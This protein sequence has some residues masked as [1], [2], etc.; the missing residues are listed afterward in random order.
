MILLAGRPD[1][2]KSS[3]FSLTSITTAIT[4]KSK[5][6]NTKVK[7]KFFSM[8]QSSFFM[9]CPKI[10]AGSRLAAKKLLSST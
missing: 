10:Q 5:M 1:F 3:V 4:A 6:E 8:Y 2:T 7:M 9:L